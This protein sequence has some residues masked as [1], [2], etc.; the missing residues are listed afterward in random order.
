MLAEHGV[1]ERLDR[2]P[3]DEGEQL[4]DLRQR[5]EKAVP[6]PGQFGQRR[7]FYY[8]FPMRLSIIVPAW[9]IDC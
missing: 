9:K 5:Q 6:Q 4:V 7:A 8:S 3:L 2:V 1:E